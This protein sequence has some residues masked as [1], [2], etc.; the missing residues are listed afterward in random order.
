MAADCLGHRS[1]DQYLDGMDAHELRAVLSTHDRHHAVG[2][3]LPV[4]R[5]GGQ[6]VEA[7]RELVSALPTGAWHPQLLAKD[8]VH[9]LCALNEGRPDLVAVDRIRGRCAVMAD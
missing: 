2:A 7:A 9:H 4:F 5:S 6:A 8:L 1:V 3:D